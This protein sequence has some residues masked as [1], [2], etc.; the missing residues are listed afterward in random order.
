MTTAC[1]GGGTFRG[2]KRYAMMGSSPF[3]VAN[4][5]FSIRHVGTASSLHS[6]RAL[7]SPLL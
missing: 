1:Q 6:V 7:S 2:R 5:T 3:A 4:D